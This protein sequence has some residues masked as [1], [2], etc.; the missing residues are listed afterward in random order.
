VKDSRER[1]GD[2]A[3]LY[4]RYRPTYPATLLDWIVGLAKLAPAAVVADIGCGTGIS[5]R[6]L[7]E[8]GF[9]VIGIDPNESM[10]ARAGRTAG[11][12][13]RTG[14]AAATG[15]P[16]QSVD[17]VTAGQ[18]FHWFDIP[19]T[20]AEFRRI[21][22]PPGWCAAFWNVRGETPFLAEYDA[23]LRRFSSEYEVILSH[24]ETLHKLRDAE[25][26]VDPREAE[27]EHVQVLDRDGVFGRARS[28]SYVAHGVA[29]VDGFERALNELF[30]RHAADGGVDFRYRTIAICWRL[31]P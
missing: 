18:A 8:R 22:R 28:S 20:L 6:L 16:D 26:V 13:Y 9:D 27:F 21:L 19:S 23:L 4:H 2:L 11:V 17:L 25:G 10:M 29:D 24:E 12:R 14:E 15:L 30:D 5:T 3:D 31:W 1:F 7:A